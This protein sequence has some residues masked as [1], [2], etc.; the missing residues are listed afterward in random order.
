M[1]GKK[2]KSKKKSKETI[3]LGDQLISEQSYQTKIPDHRRKKLEK[4]MKNINKCKKLEPK[5]DKKH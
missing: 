5:S 4:L 2:K 1:G 3:I